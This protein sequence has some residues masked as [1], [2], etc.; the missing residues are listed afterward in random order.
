MASNIIDFDNKT[1][2]G[3][4]DLSDEIIAKSCDKIDYIKRTYEY[5]RD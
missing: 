4:R 1:L 2:S 5:V 3:I